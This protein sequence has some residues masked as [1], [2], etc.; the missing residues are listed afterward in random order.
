MRYIGWRERRKE[1]SEEGRQ[2][3]KFEILDVILQERALTHLEKTKIRCER[4]KEDDETR[5]KSLR[6]KT[7]VDLASSSKREKNAPEELLEQEVDED[8]KRSVSDSLSQLELSLLG[9][10]ETLDVLFVLIELGVIQLIPRSGNED[11]VS[12]DMTGSSVVSAVRDPPRVIGDSKSRVNDPSDGVVDSL[13]E[14]EKEDE[15]DSWSDAF[16]D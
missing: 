6:G 7:I 5:Q 8:E 3:R 9:N 12:S 14:R 13:K 4:R 1:G 16:R 15:E 11:L 2:R 10:V